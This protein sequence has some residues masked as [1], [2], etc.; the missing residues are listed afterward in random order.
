MCKNKNKFV[1]VVR[2]INGRL[3]RGSYASSVFTYLA[4]MGYTSAQSPR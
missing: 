1:K 2:S 4:A 3:Y